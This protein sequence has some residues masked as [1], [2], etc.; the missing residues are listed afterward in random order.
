MK[1]QEMD[2]DSKIPF[3]I[4]F[5]CYAYNNESVCVCTLSFY[6]SS[7]SMLL[8]KKGYSVEI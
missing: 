3:N 8:R 7:E 6:K 2:L 4:H 5:R 1:C